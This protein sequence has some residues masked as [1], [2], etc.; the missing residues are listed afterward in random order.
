MPIQAL[1]TA[2]IINIILAVVLILLGIA[3]VGV[4]CWGIFHV[5]VLWLRY[6]NRESISLNS[7]LLQV[8]VPR[9]NE[10]KIDA[11]EQLFTSLYA[12][13][14]TTRFE[15]FRPQPHLSF[16]I[17]GLPGISVF[18]SMCHKSLGILWKKK[19]TEHFRRLIFYR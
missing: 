17:V 9:E 19:L 13:Y 14:G 1:S 8:T 2:N 12:L 5:F 6:R 3:I 16:E 11:A 4:I 10:T 18:M 15:Y 7:V